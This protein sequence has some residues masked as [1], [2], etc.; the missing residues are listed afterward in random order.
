MNTIHATSFRSGDI[1]TARMSISSWHDLWVP[2]RVLALGETH[3][4]IAQM[5]AYESYVT[6]TKEQRRKLWPYRAFMLPPND[7]DRY[8]IRVAVNLPYESGLGWMKRFY[9]LGMPDYVNFRPEDVLL[10]THDP[11]WNQF[12]IEPPASADVIKA[13]RAYLPGDHY[14]AKDLVWVWEGNMWHPAEVVD[15]ARWIQV[16]YPKGYRDSKGNFSK[17]CRTWQVWPVMSETSSV[18]K[19]SLNSATHV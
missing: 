5:R 3:E 12:S 14:I 11:D 8:R 9:P 15:V 1:V 16:K 10:Q 2:G 17:M 19:A 13:R 18:L 4:Y 6:A 7:L